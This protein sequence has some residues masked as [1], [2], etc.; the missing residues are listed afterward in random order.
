MPPKAVVDAGLS[1]IEIP[2]PNVPVA[3][4]PSL[5]EFIVFPSTYA[6]VTA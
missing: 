3:V 4:I 5:A 6:F 1:S 2:S